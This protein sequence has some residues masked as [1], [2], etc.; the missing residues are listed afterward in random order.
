M[1]L[2]LAEKTQRIIF[3]SKMYEEGITKFVLKTLREGMVFVD[4]GANVGYY[5]LLATSR[6]ARVLSCEPERENYARLLHNVALN[7]FS[8]QCLPIAIGKENGTM[9]LHINPLNRG[10][11]SMLSSE[12]YKTGAHRYSRKE[13]E[14]AFGVDALEQTVEV[15]KLDSLIT[16]RI[17]ILKIDVE[18]FE[19]Q[20]FEGMKGILAKGM[21]QNIICELGNKETREAVIHLLKQYDYRA[22][23]IDATG[24]PVE[25]ET[26]RD[27]LFISNKK[28]L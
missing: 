16:D 15:K 25:K 19:A 3:S 7:N 24:S 20:V 21:I 11:N 22:Y 27:L 13:V 5:S 1:E 2:D 12:V 4:V 6:G 18:G 23:S 14:V 17:T 8:I 9:L 10:G 26:G 28:G